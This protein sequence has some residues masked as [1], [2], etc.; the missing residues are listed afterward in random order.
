[1]HT[2]NEENVRAIMQHPVHMGGS[3][4][5]LHGKS[6]HPRAWG[7][8]PRYLGHYSREL[9]LIP[10]PEM[11]AHLTTR[12]AKRL[13]VYPHRGVV[14]EGSAADLV[15]FDPATVKDMS[16][17]AAPCLPAVGVK[18]VLV[19]GEA[20]L[21]DGKPTGVRAGT[22]LRRRGDGAVTAGGK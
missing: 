4:A 19:N 17:H 2:G 22:T 11:V 7:T 1:M 16:T 21:A 10:L 3:D 5:I 20:A 12:P 6:L 14:R 18:F 8:F 15:V 9:G 13:G